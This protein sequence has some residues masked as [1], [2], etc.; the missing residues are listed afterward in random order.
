MATAF[1]FSSP[2]ASPWDFC[3]LISLP[4][5]AHV[6]CIK[7]AKTTSWKTNTSTTPHFSCCAKVLHLSL[8][9]ERLK[10]L[11]WVVRSGGVGND[12][13][14]EILVC[15][16]KVLGRTMR[17][18]VIRRREILLNGSVFKCDH[19]CKTWHDGLPERQICFEWRC[20]VR[21]KRYDINT[22]LKTT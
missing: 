15:W 10:L 5:L 19:G 7:I 17:L 4:V 6:P 16:V 3:V 2:T 1:S 12:W 13:S 11:V 9:R 8:P 20:W 21:H 14:M 22:S 18:K